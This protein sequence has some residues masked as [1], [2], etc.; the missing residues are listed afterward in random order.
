MEKILDQVAK[1]PELYEKKLVSPDK[2]GDST[3]FEF[4]MLKHLKNLQAELNVCTKQLTFLGKL[5]QNLDLVVFTKDVNMYSC[6]YGENDQQLISRNIVQNCLGLHTSFIQ[7]GYDECL[8]KWIQ[9]GLVGL[10]MSRLTVNIKRLA[11][12]QNLLVLSNRPKVIPERTVILFSL[13]NSSW[14]MCLRDPSSKKEGYQFHDIS[15]LAEQINN[16]L[17]TDAHQKLTN[18]GEIELTSEK[19]ARILDILKLEQE[20]QV[21]CEV[22]FFGQTVIKDNNT[23]FLWME[24]SMSTY[25]IVIHKEEP[26]DE[27]S[28]SDKTLLILCHSK[29]LKSLNLPDLQD[30]QEQDHLEGFLCILKYPSQPVNIQSLTKCG[31]CVTLS[32]CHSHPLATYHSPCTSS[33]FIEQIGPVISLLNRYQELYQSYLPIANL[34]EILA[35][36]L[37]TE[38]CKTFF[39]SDILLLVKCIRCRFIKSISE[40]CSSIA[41][42]KESIRTILEIK[43]EILQSEDSLSKELC[44][45]GLELFNYFLAVLLEKTTSSS[46]DPDEQDSD[47]HHY[48]WYWQH[49][50]EIKFSK[51]E[52]KS[53]LISSTYLMNSEFVDQLLQNESAIARSQSY[54]HIIEGLQKLG[55]RNEFLAL[56]MKQSLSEAFLCTEKGK[57]DVIVEYST[58]LVPD[59][60]NL[61]SLLSMIK[62]NDSLAEKVMSSLPSIGFDEESCHDLLESHKFFADI[63][64]TVFDW[65]ANQLYT[66]FLEFQVAISQLFFSERTEINTM[67]DFFASWVMSGTEAAFKENKWDESQQYLRIAQTLNMEVQIVLAEAQ[68]CREEDIRMSSSYLITVIRTVMVSVDLTQVSA[69][70][71]NHSSEQWLNYLMVSNF[72]F[73]LQQ[74]YSTTISQ[75]LSD[76]LLY[77]DS[78]FLQ[79]LYNVFVSDQYNSSHNFHHKD[80]AGF[81]SLEQFLSL[82]NW[83]NL[84]EPCPSAYKVLCRTSLALWEKELAEI[85]FKQYIDHWASISEA[86]KIKTVYLMNRVRLD[87]GVNHDD[88]IEFLCMV[89]RKYLSCHEENPTIFLDLFEDLYYKRVSLN[90]VSVI[91]SE[92]KYKYWKEHL[93]LIKQQKRET[94]EPREVIN[95]LDLIEAQ[96][97]SGDY[98]ISSQ[99]F[100]VIKLEAKQII[101]LVQSFNQIVG[102]ISFDQFKQDLSNLLSTSVTIEEKIEWLEKENHRVEFIA[103]MVTAW[104]LATAKAGH[105]QDPYNTQIV[106]L[107]LFL[108]SRDMGLLQQVKTGEGKTLIVAML[109][110]AKALLGYQV[111]IVSSNRDLAQDGMRKC[112]PFFKLLGLQ[113]GVN[114]TDDEDT[115]QQAY[116]SHIVYGD[117]GSF[118]RDVL[119]E[120]CGSGG[121]N[122]HTRYPDHDLSKNCLIVDEV[123]SMFLD[124][125]Q[126]MLYLSHETAAL[127]HLETLFIMIWSAVLSVSQENE[128]LPVSEVTSELAHKLSVLIDNET[129]T[130]PRYLKDF[131]KGKLESWVRSAY[132]ARFMDVDDQFIIDSRSQGS[133]VKQIFPIDKQTGLEQYNMKWTDGLSQFLELKY[134]R[135]LS[136][137]SLR[138]VFISNKRFFRHYGKQLYGL[139]GTLGSASSRSLLQNVYNI[140]TVEL[141]TNRPKRYIQTKSRVATSSRMWCELIKE[142]VCH[143]IKQ[144]PVLVICENIKQLILLRDYIE[145]EASIEIIDYKRDGDDVEKKFHTQGGACPGQ[146]IL[147][148][149]KGGRGTDIKVDD[150]EAPKGLHVIVTFLPENTRIEE[151]AFGRA[152]RAGQAGSGCLIIQIS[153]G[154]YKETINEFRML[155]AATETLIEMEKIKRNRAETERLTLLLNEGIPKLD[156]EENMY[157]AFRKHRK[158]LMVALDKAVLFEIKVDG[159]QY[160]KQACLSIATNHWA[161]WLES[162]RVQIGSADTSDK[163]QAVEDAFNE[164]FPSEC[165]AAPSTNEDSTF[166]KM[167]ED[168]IQLGQAYLKE[169][170]YLRET[171]YLSQLKKENTDIINSL[172]EAALICF[173][174]AIDIGDKTGLAAMTACH[175]FVK[176]NPA[177]SKENK[178]RVRCYL[179]QASSQLTTLKQ[180]WM[181]NVEASKALAGLLDVSQYGG[182]CENHYAQ[183][184]E[185]KLKVIGLHLHIIDTLLGSPIEESSFEME[186]SV[187]SISAEKSKELYHSLCESK[188]I[189][190]NKVR[191]CW[192]KREKLEPLIQKEVEPAIAEQLIQLILEKQAIDKDDLK[193]LVYSSE[194]LWDQLDPLIGPN[195][196]VEILEVE[197]IKNKLSDDELVRNWATFQGEIRIDLSECTQCQLASDDPAYERLHSKEFSELYSY[198]SKSGLCVTTRRAALKDDAGTQ[199]E[200]INFGKFEECK[201]PGEEQSLRKY[202]AEIIDYCIEQEGGYL[203]EHMLPF[204]NK[205][206]EV[207]KLHTFLQQHDIL[208]SGEL[209]VCKYDSENVE[210]ESLVRKSVEKRLTEEQCAFV[211]SVLRGLQ[212]EVRKFERNMQINLVSFYDLK[213]RP[214]DV[215]EELD[216]FTTW[217]LDYFLSLDQKDKGWWDWN[218]F[219]CAVIGLAQVAVGLALVTT[220]VASQI[221]FGLIAEGISDMV[222]ATTAGLTGTFSW[223]DYATQKAISVAVSVATGG[224]SALASPVR[225][226]A[227][228]GSAARY[229]TFLKTAIKAAGSF[230]LNVSASILSDVVLSGVQER[231]V[232]GIVSFIENNLFPSIRGRI[233]AKLT[234]EAREAKSVKE[235]HTRTESLI[236]D[237]RNQLGLDRSNVSTLFDQL[238]SQLISSL[239][240][241]CN[242]IADKLFTSNSKW[243]KLV[244]TGAKI[245]CLTSH[246]L[247]LVT[248]SVKLM[249][250]VNR[251]MDLTVLRSTEDSLDSSIHGVDDTIL[252]AVDHEIEKIESI[253]KEFIHRQLREKI[254]MAL[255]IAVRKTL[256]M[257]AKATKRIATASMEKAFN[258]KSTFQLVQEMRARNEATEMHRGGV[259]TASTEQVQALATE[260]EGLSK[261]KASLLKRDNF[262]DTIVEPKHSQHSHNLLYTEDISVQAQARKYAA[263][264]AKLT[265]LAPITT[266][267]TMALKP[268]APKLAAKKTDTLPSISTTTKPGQRKPR[269]RKRAVKKRDKHILS[270]LTNPTKHKV[271]KRKMASKRSDELSTLETTFALGELEVPQKSIKIKRHA[272]YLKLHKP[273]NVGSIGGSRKVAGNL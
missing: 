176:L 272:K 182:V 160:I 68:N 245:A 168:Y 16:E 233:K 114:C 183:Q 185:G 139:T 64:D 251:L 33:T 265:V 236:G 93:E 150:T 173:Q 235:F 242:G 100:E 224:L 69:I 178:K 194:E 91:V 11:P 66:I 101:Y 255:S 170:T 159:T 219:A 57:I 86:D 201:I 271:P 85:Y 43:D 162:M 125:G 158:A 135:P 270:P 21:A 32:S 9:P 214:E 191:S 212:G 204:A 165:L 213:D 225:V 67:Y 34:K 17:G 198:L 19:K 102:T 30:L 237:L 132:E 262:Q 149:N 232:E 24:I 70:L 94:H 247:P 222:Y 264:D 259:K 143:I 164:N 121:V 50:L 254:R 49:I 152:A 138:A 136:A 257:V 35:D 239:A 130:V 22:Q 95:I 127:K 177:A 228:V 266:D 240:Q 223:K 55:S 79:I 124:K 210:F 51:E 226:A 181:G 118:Q 4:K 63:T 208:K 207:K 126:H 75:E 241:N 142:D 169:I 74:Y 25:E 246:V 211:L 220:A 2:P 18:D 209:A 190:H 88:F 14:K 244:G 163:R 23:T 112:Q 230:I 13:G 65:C 26:T 250:T 189:C 62:A 115:N 61:H 40:N 48:F 8:I 90:Q 39:D 229:S 77:L 44:L 258:N 193:F 117:V 227:K 109:A 46:V 105:K 5:Q 58:Q 206:Q 252:K 166:F 110:A 129:I 76:K 203:Y 238:Q 215:P 87:T 200:V 171:T 54:H 99:Q 218:A 15:K 253:F 29:C 261:Q 221:G 104:G 155:V 37:A 131:C 60:R 263:Q 161:F 197:Q 157:D 269:K 123:D 3:E 103:I 111:D 184:I 116:K 107:L 20:F 113:A 108:H 231:V 96:I 196:T 28:L 133:H 195:E 151:Q 153:E 140:K 27:A 179:K 56:Q 217:H 128:M 144:Q 82:L 52:A 205:S 41:G 137:E 71:E 31:K 83:L 45:I 12:Q 6:L 146:L 148:T 167:P 89:R 42:N 134:Q 268:D 186:P 260:G 192:K 187:E 202:M 243:A 53:V 154:E 106:S 119:M 38:D 59:S 249:Y 141:P 175:C 273:V 81:I 78:K 156:M 216:F 97:H 180:G 72:S 188:I 267:G 80:L 145:P 10:T 248:N 7:A 84:I 36:F 47:I 256:Q 92:H 73:V 1:K 172:Y 120:E 234:Q 174:R 98:K 199:I 147:A 122:F